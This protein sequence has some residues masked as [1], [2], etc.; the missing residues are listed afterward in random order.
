MFASAISNS[1]TGSVTRRNLLR[2][3]PLVLAGGYGV[4]PR[5][6]LAAMSTFDPLFWSQPRAINV[7]APGQAMREFMYWRDGSYQMDEYLALSAACLDEREGKAVQMAP[8]LFDI[9]FATQQQF[10]RNEG[11]ATHHE[12]TSAYRTKTT[13]AIVGGSPR[14]Q[15][16]KGAALDGKL[17]GVDL[18]TYA[19]MVRSYAA[20][21]VGLYGKH[22]HWDVGRPAFFWRGRGAE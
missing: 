10:M 9:M 4:L 8:G 14:S 11:K 6:S 13:N 17:I 22:V 5:K 15:H 18:S 2:V 20:G 19:A 1:L 16:M 7:R 21:G 3:V 12:I